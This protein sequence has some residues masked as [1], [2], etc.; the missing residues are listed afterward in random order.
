MYTYEYEP[1]AFDFSG[2]GPFQGNA[3]S[4]FTDYHKIIEKRANEGWRYVG[5]VPVR[6][7][8]TGHV[9]QIELIFEKEV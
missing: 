4:M 7:R 1:V 6:L 2:W 5:Y 8:N 9:E 3:Y